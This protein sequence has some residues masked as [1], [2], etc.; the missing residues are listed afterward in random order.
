MFYSN[1]TLCMLIHIGRR[2]QMNI[3]TNTFLPKNS[4]A[5][6]W[7]SRFCVACQTSEHRKCAQVSECT[8][9]QTKRFKDKNQLRS[10]TTDIGD[11]G[12][13]AGNGCHGDANGLGWDSSARIDCVTSSFKSR[14]WHKLQRSRSCFV[15]GVTCGTTGNTSRSHLP[16]PSA[17][18]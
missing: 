14:D 13:T 2:H 12:S 18:T 16:D 17:G 11:Q 7:Y 3:K 15:C 5:F 1:L 4:R 9:V 8:H 10:G 6:P